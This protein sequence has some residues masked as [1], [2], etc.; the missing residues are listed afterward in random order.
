MRGPSLSTLRIPA[1]WH[2]EPSLHAKA[3]ERATR[4][5][6]LSL[7]LLPKVQAVVRR[8][9]AS[10]FGLLAA[11][12]YPRGTRERLELCNDWHVWLFLFDDEADERQE[13]GQR[14]EY[15]QAYVEACLEVLR[16]GPLRARATPLECFTHDLR[17]R[18]RRL[19]S[20]MWLERFAADVE[21]YLYRGTLP[22]ARHWAAGTVP[23]L[24][25][26]IEQRAMDSAM[27][28]AQ[29]LVEFAR[30]GQ[31][32]P[33]LLFHSPRVQRLRHL[34]S[35][36][37]GLTNDLFS[38][39]KEVLWHRN[40]NNFVHVLRVNRGLGLEEAIHQALE[41]INEDTDAFIACEQELLASGPVD[42][43]VLSYVEGM[44]AWIR[45]NVSWSMVTGRYSSPT[46]PFPELRRPP[47]GPLTP[48]VG[49][50]G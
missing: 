34:C 43:R 22:A 4:A 26:Y 25:P 40:P 45:G 28:T 39:E 32:L 29:D 6:V 12:T 27:Y 31:E 16:G 48:R 5:R 37:V 35:R 33:E 38:F 15:L 41:L 3:I 47:G 8:F 23:E 30:E 11:Y 19:A 7:K 9:D 44:K 1:S 50:R 21:D 17:K 18:L 2:S 46:S 24:E 14:P 10:Q 42:P 13:V 36:V 49:G 20:G